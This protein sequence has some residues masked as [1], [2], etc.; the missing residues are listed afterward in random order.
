MTAK[1]FQKVLDGL[2]NALWCSGVSEHVPTIKLRLGSEGDEEQRKLLNVKNPDDLAALVSVC[3]TAPCG[4]GTEDV[5]DLGVRSTVQTD[6]SV[7]EVNFEGLQEALDEVQRKLAPF[8]S[9]SAEFYKLLVYRQGDF[10]KP[11]R[12]SKKGDGHILTLA[13]DCGCE[14]RGGTLKFLGG[15]L[16]NRK[17][18]GEGDEEDESEEE[19]VEEEDEDGKDAEQETQF[20]EGGAPATAAAAATGDVKA[21][22]GGGIER[23]STSGETGEQWM[24]GGRG[25][26][27]CCWINSVFHEVTSMRGG[28]RVTAVFNI[29][30]ADAK[31]GLPVMEEGPRFARRSVLSSDSVPFP[32]QERS[33]ES[34]Q[35]E[36]SEA[37]HHSVSPSPSSGG[38]FLFFPLLQMP[39]EALEEF[40]SF[41]DAVTLCALKTSGRFLASR[42]FLEDFVAASL[43]RIVH[44]PTEEKGKEG[45]GTVAPCEWLIIPMRNTYSFYGTQRGKPLPI[46]RHAQIFGADRIVYEGIRKAV[47]EPPMIFQSA[48]VVYKKEEE[49][50]RMREEEKQKRTPCAYGYDVEGNVRLAWFPL[51]IPDPVKAPDQ[52]P[53]FCLKTAK[54]LEKERDYSGLALQAVSWLRDLLTA[55]SADGDAS[56]GGSSV[57]GGHRDGVTTLGPGDANGYCHRRP[58]SAS[59]GC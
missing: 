38:T 12:D 28:K 17:E 20:G 3:E 11:H 59:A 35:Q 43:G 1:A 32:P 45:E 51:H 26:S 34:L 18:Y 55:P 8:S 15:Q 23:L 57:E 36:T 30:C 21:C 25:G 49:W 48:A 33:F 5:K 24:S 6:V 42:I 53:S 56:D 7:V 9:L 4:K 52:P 2:P 41:L 54:A 46:E 14:C 37:D 13:V 10:F 29:S 27:W 31:G 39:G 40:V 19:W 50:K 47:G 16:L 44:P 58:P 22:K